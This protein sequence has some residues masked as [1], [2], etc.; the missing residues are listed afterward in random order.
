M[1]A[2]ARAALMLKERMARLPLAVQRAISEIARQGEKSPP[3]IP[4]VKDR[5]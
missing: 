4:T 5:A 1:V 2:D 3:P